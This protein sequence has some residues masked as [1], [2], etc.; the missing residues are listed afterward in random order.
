M[1]TFFKS[2]C[3][4]TGSKDILPHTG[5]RLGPKTGHSDKRGVEKD[6]RQNVPGGE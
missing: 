5:E 6:V 4:N 3:R 2:S 1:K